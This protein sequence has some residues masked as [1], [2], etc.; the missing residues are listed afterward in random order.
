M[1]LDSGMSTDLILAALRSAADETWGD[2][3]SSELEPALETC[4]LALWRLAQAPLSFLEDEP[5]Y[6]RGMAPP[7]EG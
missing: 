4:A 5:D 6:A 1:R 3:R 2:D 7:H